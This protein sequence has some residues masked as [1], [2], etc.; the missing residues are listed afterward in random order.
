MIGDSLFL[1][2]TYTIYRLL[3]FHCFHRRISETVAYT[4]LFE[5]FVIKVFR[6]FIYNNLCAL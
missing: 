2:V 6:R 3:F 1:L 5:R 4:S